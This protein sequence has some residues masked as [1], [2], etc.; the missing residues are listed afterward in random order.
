MVLLACLAAQHECS[1][2][3]SLSQQ[4]HCASRRGSNQV[5]L[6]CREL[7]A[8]K[9]FCSLEPPVKEP[10]VPQSSISARAFLQLILGQSLPAA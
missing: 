7:K 2:V 10:P 8:A 6:L 9:P 5:C 3:G 1:Q 4:G